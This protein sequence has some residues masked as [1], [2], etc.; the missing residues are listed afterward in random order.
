MDYPIQFNM[1]H[2][3]HLNKAFHIRFMY[4][5]FMQHANYLMLGAPEPLDFARCHATCVLCYVL[6][7]LCAVLCTGHLCHD[8]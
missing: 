1:P 6:N 2:A 4:H 5:A 8:V 7:I 3:S